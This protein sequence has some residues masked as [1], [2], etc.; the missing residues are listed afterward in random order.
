MKYQSQTV[1]KDIFE[2][3]RELPPIYMDRISFH[4]HK[5]AIKLMHHFKDSEEEVITFIS[6]FLKPEKFKQDDFVYFK[7]D[8]I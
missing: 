1:G 7:G 3:I 4:I 8:L 6:G 2:F 5:E